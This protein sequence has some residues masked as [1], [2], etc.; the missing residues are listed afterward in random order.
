MRT[1][2]LCHPLV[3]EP[4]NIPCIVPIVPGVGFVQL[5]IFTALTHPCC[6][7]WCHHKLLTFSFVG[8][9]ARPNTAS[10]PSELPGRSSQWQDI[11]A[12]VDLLYRH[13][14]W[15]RQHAA[16]VPRLRRVGLSMQLGFF[17]EFF[18]ADV[19]KSAG[20]CWCQS[21]MIDVPGSSRHPLGQLAYRIISGNDWYDAR[22]VLEDQKVGK[23][24]DPLTSDWPLLLPASKNC[25]LYPGLWSI[26]C[27]PGQ[28]WD[29]ASSSRHPV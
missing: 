26:D 2:T 25:H 9:R 3:S 22:T 20:C 1:D 18:Y 4:V 16:H 14:L 17:N 15:C 10:C 19:S 6:P 21:D 23:C 12:P 29:H 13:G 28:L 7:E 5:A 24:P 11:H 8:R 27:H